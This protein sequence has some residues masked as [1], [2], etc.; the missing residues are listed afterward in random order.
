MSEVQN[1]ETAAEVP[2]APTKSKKEINQERLANLKA[3]KERKVAEKAAA[4]VTEK[5]AKVK[6]EPKEKV[7]RACRC[8]CG[9]QTTAYFVPGHDARFKG[10]LKKIELGKK[11]VKE[12]PP[13][14]QKEYVFTRRGI[15]MVPD[16][17][18]KGNPYVPQCSLEDVT[19]ETAAETGKKGAK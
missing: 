4:P 8:G 17:D 3:A 12:L 7:V 5:A 11:E 13:S 14:V 19:E 16:K 10:W 1:V 6:R 9:G 18:Y 15:G 2:I